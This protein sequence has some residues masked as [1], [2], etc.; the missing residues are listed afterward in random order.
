M[1][2]GRHTACAKTNKVSRILEQLTVRAQLFLFHGKMYIPK[3]FTKNSIGPIQPDPKFQIYSA[4]R[5]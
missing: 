1:Q 4:L 2:L 5:P 3:M